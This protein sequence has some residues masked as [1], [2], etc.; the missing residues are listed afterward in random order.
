MLMLMLM[1]VYVCS[2]LKIHLSIVRNGRWV[3]QFLIWSWLVQPSIYSMQCEC[4]SGWISAGGGCGLCELP[5]FHF[6]SKWYFAS[7]FLSH[8][9]DSLITSLMLISPFERRSS[10]CQVQWLKFTKFNFD[11]FPSP[12]LPL[13]SSQG[14]LRFPS[15]IWGRYLVRREGRKVLPHFFGPK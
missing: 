10:R 4:R 8:L 11:Q 12:T 15:W 6:R 3:A 9:C 5:Q 7:Q 2:V 13:G 1:H 14:S